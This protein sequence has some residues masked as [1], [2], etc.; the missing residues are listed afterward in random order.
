[1]K[2][3]NAGIQSEDSLLDRL[4]HFLFL[5]QGTGLHLFLLFSIDQAM[6]WGEASG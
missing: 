6:I 3:T 2:K 5:F 4:I 1:M